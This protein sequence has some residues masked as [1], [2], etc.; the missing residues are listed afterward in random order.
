MI[1]FVYNIYE[2][3]YEF[4]SGANFNETDY[5][6]ANTV[7]A[8]KLF[9]YRNNADYC[10]VR[11][12]LKSI[13]QSVSLADLHETE[14]DFVIKHTN[15]LAPEIIIAYLM[16]VNEMEADAAQRYYMQ[17]R[18]ADIKSAAN[19][20]TKRIHSDEFTMTLLM[21]LG[22][23][24][25]EDFL[26]KARNAISD[27]QQSAIL[28]TNYGNTVSGIMDFLEN[29]GYYAENGLAQFA[30]ADIQQTK[31]ALIDTLYNGY[32]S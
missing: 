24:Q 31:K 7:T 30:S 12:C 27:L 13:M 21:Q 25:A 16:Q 29:T 15:A 2:D 20:Y 10:Q 9:A 17:L 8:L 26:F 11:D 3:R 28:G 6:D 32:E 19:C 18:V 14:A 23:Q 5:E 22:Q 4:I 1:Q